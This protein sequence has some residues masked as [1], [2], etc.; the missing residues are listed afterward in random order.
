VEALGLMR[1]LGFNITRQKAAPPVPVTENRGGWL[2]IIRESFTG[3]WQKG[4]TLDQNEIISYPAVYSCITLIASDIAKLRV[5]LME[6]NEKDG[7]WTE[8]QSPSF[9]PVLRKPNHYQTRVQFWENWVLS[10]LTRGNTYALKQRDGRGVVT[11]LYILD[12]NRVKV[13]VSDDGSVYYQ[14]KADN[15]ATLEQDILV[16]AS[17][18]IHDRMNCL[19]HPLIGTSP[20]M[21]AGI[22]A[23]QG[24]A[25]QKGSAWFFGNRSQPGGVLTAPGTI[26]HDTAAR[27][28]ETWDTNFTG[29]NAGKVAVLG[30]GL[31]FERLA[32]TAEESQLIEQLKW[33]AEVICSVFH[34]PGYMIGVG[35]I[36]TSGNVE[37]EQARYY[38]QALQVLIEA[39]EICLDEGLGLSEAK[40]GRRYGTEFDLDGLMRMDTATQYKAI[41]DG[42]RGGF[43]TPNEGRSQIGKKPLVG[44]DTVYLQEQDH[45]LQALAERDAGPDPFGDGKTAQSEPPANDNAELEAA[46]AMAEIYKGLR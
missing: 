6:Y 40:D 36:P 31:S 4:V 24:M 3:A 39:A 19:F 21:A 45:S 28:K 13:M 42:I 37:T 35:S 26:H 34:V 25:I 12:P 8:V 10:K 23:T 11:A 17:E 22:T 2:P 30:D 5:K 46:K 43:L 29:D 33:T 27:I 38:S 41:S 15:M 1:I 7:I 9:S 14:L 18:I 16:P 20:I 32:M 44:G